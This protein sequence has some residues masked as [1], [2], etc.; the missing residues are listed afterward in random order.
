MRTNA[1]GTWLSK[2]RGACYL[3]LDRVDQ[4]SYG[5]DKGRFVHCRR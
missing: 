4:Q 3:R 1:V 5:A 2:S